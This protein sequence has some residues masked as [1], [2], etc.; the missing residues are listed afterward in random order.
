MVVAGSCGQ[1]GTQPVVRWGDRE[2]PAMG[3]G[4]ADRRGFAFLLAKERSEMVPG[5]FERERLAADMQRLEWLAAAMLGPG[6]SSRLRR[7]AVPSGTRRT[8]PLGLCR[9]GFAIA[10]DLNRRICMIRPRT[11]WSLPGEVPDQEIA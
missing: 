11:G 4:D 2:L 9:R 8:V 1:S 5:M 6:R 3:R 7:T 10:Q